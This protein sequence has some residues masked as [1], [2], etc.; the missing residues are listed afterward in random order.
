MWNAAG[1][2]P[3]YFC[4]GLQA[5]VEK[6]ADLNPV[7]QKWYMDDGGIIGPVDLLKQVWEILSNEGPPMGLL[8]NA[9]KCEWSWLNRNCRDPCPLDRVALVETS[10]IQILGVPL[11]SA[12][13]ASEYVASSYRQPRK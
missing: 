11:G 1:L 7:Y 10:K 13:F 2:G 3:L 9:E 12:E 8:L 4:C 6:I 5:L